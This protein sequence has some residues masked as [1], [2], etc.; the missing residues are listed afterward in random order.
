M[1][2][3][4]EGTENGH[5]EKSRRAQRHPDGLAATESAREQ[6]LLGAAVPPASTE[7]VKVSQRL[8]RQKYLRLNVLQ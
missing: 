6:R 1:Q 2:S 5:K 3:R 8:K 4:D 7:N